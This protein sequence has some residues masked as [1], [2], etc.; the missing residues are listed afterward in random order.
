MLLMEEILHQLLGTVVSPIVYRFM[1]HKWCRISS[2]NSSPKRKGPSSQKGPSHKDGIVLQP[3]IFRG[4][5][6][7]LGSVTIPD[8]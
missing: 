3:L 5:L 7:V 2:T 6:L 4:H 8:C 1:H